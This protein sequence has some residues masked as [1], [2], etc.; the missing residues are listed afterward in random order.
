MTHEGT[1][2]AVQATEEE[3]LEGRAYL[4]E[5]GLS[6][7]EERMILDH[8]TGENLPLSVAVVRC[9][10]AKTAIENTAEMT[11]DMGG[12]DEMVV[13]Q[14]TKFLDKAEKDAA[15]RMHEQ[16]EQQTTEREA[17]TLSDA[18]EKV[19]ERRQTAEVTHDLSKKN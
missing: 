16:E 13:S 7:L 4:E 12:T 14:V 5:Q 8:T 3:L 18:V 1:P 19:Q 6:E 10:Y 2:P 17:A 15:G 11:R 9:G